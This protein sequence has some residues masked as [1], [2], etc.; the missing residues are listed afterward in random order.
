MSIIGRDLQLDELQLKAQILQEKKELLKKYKLL[1]K[2]EINEY[3]IKT[4]TDYLQS[5]RSPL[6]SKHFNIT[7]EIQSIKDELE[8]RQYGREGIKYEFES[9]K[10]A[11]DREFEEHKILDLMLNDMYNIILKGLINTGFIGTS[12]YDLKNKYPKIHN[13][14]SSYGYNEINIEKSKSY[15]VNLKN[16]KTSYGLQIIS[17]PNLEYTE[18]EVD[19]IWKNHFFNTFKLKGSKHPKLVMG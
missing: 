8:F 16:S 9:I 10:R 14:I 6:K 15:V 12:S 3:F 5:Y 11:I 7:C 4:L 1:T 17:N 18:S 13:I 19:T 2:K